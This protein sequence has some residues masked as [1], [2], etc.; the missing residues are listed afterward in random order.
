VMFLS[1]EM[2]VS[3]ITPNVPGAVAVFACAFQKFISINVQNN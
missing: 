3:P 1:T 2:S